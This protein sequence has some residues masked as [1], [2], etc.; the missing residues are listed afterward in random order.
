MLI[1]LNWIRDYVDLPGDLDPI[2]LAE[3]FTRTTAEVDGVHRVEVAARGLIA[4]GVKNVGPLPGTKNLRLVTLDIGGGKIVETVSAAPVLEAGDRVVYAPPGASVK[5]LG[6]IGTTT[7][8]GKT[9][10]GMILAADSLGIDAAGQEAVFLSDEYKPG[11]PLPAELFDDWLIE[12]D[13][14]SLTNRPDLWGHYG[15]AREIA[16]IVHRPLKP[17][18]IVALDELTDAKLP[19]VPIKIAD[20]RACRRYTGL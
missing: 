1:S 7:V 2:A 8:A 4:A 15:V 10:T 12:I 9:S 17:Y 14:K 5:S 16:A 3:K 6:A 11:D 13:N 19:E 18:P 20:P